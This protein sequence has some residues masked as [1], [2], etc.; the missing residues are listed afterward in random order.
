L[1]NKLGRKLFSK[2]NLKDLKTPLL[3]LLFF[4]SLG[5]WRYLITDKIFYL[6]N[7]TYIGVA[8]GIGILLN[9][10]LDKENKQWGRK[11]TQL[12][13]GIYMLG[14]LGLIRKDNMQLEGF[15]FYLLAGIFAAATLHYFIAKIFGPLIFGRGWCGWACWTAM[16][17]DLL[18][19]SNQKNRKQNFGKI[20]YIH[21]ILSLVIVIYIMINNNNIFSNLNFALYWLAF[22]NIT[23]YIIGISLAFFLRDKRAFCKYVCPI[24]TLQKILTRFSLL[25][26][27]VESHKCIDCHICEKHCPMGIKIIKYKKEG[28]RVLSTE[29]ILCQSC[30]DICP[31]N[32]VD[33]TLGLDGQINKEYIYYDQS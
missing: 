3:F 7:F 28:K 10:N 11:I 21:F 20:R 31:T 32:A 30:K 24:P 26:I 8:L 23:Y 13:I 29:C 6:Y 17:L 12:L 2:Q 15:F 27:E 18:P 19:E 4:L 16:V 9:S 1:K 33:V 22:G 14:Y 5:I 25:K